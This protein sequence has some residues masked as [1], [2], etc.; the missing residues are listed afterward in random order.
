MEI[1]EPGIYNI[2]LEEYHSDP[3]K[4][5]SLSRSVIMDL[6]YRSPAHAWFNHP[7]LN[8]N[9]K[10]EEDEPKFDIGRAA[11]PL[12]LE[13]LD[14][15]AIINADDWRKKETKQERDLARK[16]GKIPL[17][18]S[19]YLRVSEMVK[20]AEK[21]IIGCKELGINHLYGSGQAELSYFWEEDGIWIRSRPDW[22]SQDKILILDYKTTQASANPNEVARAIISNGYDIQASLALR[23]VK[24][25]NKIEPK[26]VFVFQETEEPYLCS[27]VGL[28]PQFLEM[29]KQ[30]VE[31]GI[32]LWRECL[33]RNEWPG[34][35]NQVAW[36][37]SP[38]WALAQWE[39]IATR[40]G[41]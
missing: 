19:Q 25:I 1:K 4:I 14:N 8:P 7:R 3:C 34:Y 41:V 22:I 20:V 9:F 28:P 2:S 35:P 37:E 12:L 11:H 40:I 6:I 5:P 27:F 31:Y 36:I 10:L 21:Q 15:A 13:G 26:F 16:E 32:F 17:L 33:E 30:K 29:G 23:A 39:G 24:A 38:A 18:A